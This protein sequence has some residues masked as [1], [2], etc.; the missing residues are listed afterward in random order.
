[1]TTTVED[2]AGLRVLQAPRPVRSGQRMGLHDMA[3]ELHFLLWGTDIT[4]L[5]SDSAFVRE[6]G[7][8][9]VLFAILWVKRIGGVGGGNIQRM[10]ATSLP[11]LHTKVHSM[12]SRQLCA[13]NIIF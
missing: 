1:M 4:L 6:V 7:V 2:A 3:R 10:I 8:K 13:V 12:L 9:Y 5:P 11:L